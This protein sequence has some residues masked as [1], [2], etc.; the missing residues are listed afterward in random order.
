MYSF[1]GKVRAIE[2]CLRYDRSAVAVINEL[3]CPNRHTFRLWYKEF[4]MRA[5]WRPPFFSRRRTSRLGAL[6]M[7]A[8][9]Q[10]VHPACEELL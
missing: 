5:L 1:E 10:P 3:G 7:L 2:L 9:L 6:A 8:G 4:P